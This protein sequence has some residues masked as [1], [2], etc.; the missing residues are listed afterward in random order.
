MQMD[1]ERA[2]DKEIKKLKPWEFQ[3]EPTR[4]TTFGQYKPSA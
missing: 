4:Q 1:Y 2:R 3:Q